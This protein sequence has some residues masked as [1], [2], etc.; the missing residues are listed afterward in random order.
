M[1]IKELPPLILWGINDTLNEYLSLLD[2]AGFKTSS[3]VDT[4]TKSYR[5]IPVITP[6]EYKNQF[7]NLQ[8]Y[9]VVIIPNNTFCTTIYIFFIIW[10]NTFKCIF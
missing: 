5:D 3:I 10:H 7:R 2:G 8:N 6:E 4:K 1:L 9:P